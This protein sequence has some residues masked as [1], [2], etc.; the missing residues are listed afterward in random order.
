MKNI[1]KLLIKFKKNCLNQKNIIKNMKI[2]II[3]VINNG[4]SYAKRII[5][6]NKK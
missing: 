3:I 2:E 4:I 5:K 6:N 1:L